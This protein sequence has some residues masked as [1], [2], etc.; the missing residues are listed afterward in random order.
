M[1]ITCLDV[2]RIS[3]RNLDRICRSKWNPGIENFTAMSRI[4]IN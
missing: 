4:M 1:Y 2:K 3:T